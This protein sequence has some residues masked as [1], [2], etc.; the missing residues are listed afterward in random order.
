MRSP[1]NDHKTI[2]TIQ[3]SINISEDAGGSQ[4][5]VE[6]MSKNPRE[7]IQMLENP[8]AYQKTIGI[9]A[10]SIQQFVTV[11]FTFNRKCGRSK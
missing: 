2:Q 7:S 6:I 4:K 11:T 10:K 3:D 5:V 8:E 9:F 1:N